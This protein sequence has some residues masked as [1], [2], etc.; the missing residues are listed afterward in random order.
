MTV[1]WIVEPAESVIKQGDDGVRCILLN[2]P[3]VVLPREL[4]FSGKHIVRLKAAEAPDYRSV[5]V[6]D[7]VYCRRVSH[8]EKIV[9]I[10][11]FIY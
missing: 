5:G 8:G 7:L 3:S 2:V 4:C 11:E 1:G 9:S 10:W 6:R